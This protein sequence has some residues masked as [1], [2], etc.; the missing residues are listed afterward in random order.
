MLVTELHAVL[1]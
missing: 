1:Q